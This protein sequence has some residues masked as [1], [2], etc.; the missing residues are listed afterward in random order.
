MLQLRTE[1]LHLR[2]LQEGDWELFLRLSSDPSVRIWQSFLPGSSE[3]ECRQWV[4]DMMFHNCQRPRFG[5]NFAMLVQLSGEEIGWI[6]FGHA[7]DKQVGDREFGFAVLPNYWSRGYTTEALREVLSLAFSQRDANTIYGEC[8]S[9]NVASARV[10]Q[11]CGMKLVRRWTERSENQ[12]DQENERY[13]IERSEWK[14][15]NRP[16][17][18]WDGE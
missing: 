3:P 2:E 10:M 13:L 9:L 18:G 16:A 4:R 6:G 5:Y 15:N 11:K 7:S 1:R 12:P 8:N 17:L 14:V